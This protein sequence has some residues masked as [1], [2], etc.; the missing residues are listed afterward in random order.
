VIREQRELLEYM[1]EL[2][3]QGRT[4]V[5]LT[6][7]KACMEELAAA[8]RVVDEAR[9]WLK[10][11]KAHGSAYDGLPPALEAYDKV[12]QYQEFERKALP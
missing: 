2:A 10:W 6:T 4:E 1:A 9:G 5:L 12:K 3:R 7:V 11:V 8:E